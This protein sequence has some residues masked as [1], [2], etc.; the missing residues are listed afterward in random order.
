MGAIIS[1]AGLGPLGAILDPAMAA[2]DVRQ[3]ALAL[4][5][6]FRTPRAAVEPVRPDGRLEE[7]LG[8]FATPSS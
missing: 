5:D 3:L 8:P 2:V 1:L 6:V 4:R 7:K